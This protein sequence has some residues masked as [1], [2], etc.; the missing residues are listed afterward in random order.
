MI[1]VLLVEDD[2]FIAR[3]IT[4][5]LEGKRSCR[6]HCARTSGEALG[7]ARGSFDLILL[8]VLL[9]DADGIGLCRQLRQWHDCPIIFVS[10]MDD[11]D[12]IIRNGKPNMTANCPTV[13]SRRKSP[14]TSIN[15]SAM[16]ST[17]TC[18]TYFVN[19]GSGNPPPSTKPMVIMPIY[20]H[21]RYA[22]RG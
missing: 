10:S 1:D 17:P 5:Y 2:D 7:L 11:S 16:P 4:Y 6:V 15:S 12:T 13:F 20:A 22:G 9:P 19:H 8:D 18:I 14:V 21:F 3:T